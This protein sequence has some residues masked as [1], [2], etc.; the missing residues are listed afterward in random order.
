LEKASEICEWLRELLGDQWVEA[1]ALWAAAREQEFSTRRVKAALHTLGAV[2]EKRDFKGRWSYRLP[3]KS[4][5]GS[6]S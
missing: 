2:A 4:S 5:T 3:A 6:H 1:K